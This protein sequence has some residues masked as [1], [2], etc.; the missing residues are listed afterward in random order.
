LTSRRCLI[1]VLTAWSLMAWDLFLDPL[2]V[3]PGAWRWAPTSPSIPGLDG[4]PL[5]N[6]AG[7]FAVGLVVGIVLL[8]LPSARAPVAQPAVL[9]LWVYVSS[10]VGAAFFFDDSGAAVVGGIAM[11]IVAIPYLWRLWVDRI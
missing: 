4:I 2:M 6:A 3:E 10:V 7:W 8:A 9:F 5:V 11:G 1:P